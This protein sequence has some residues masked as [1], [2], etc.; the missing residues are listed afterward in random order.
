MYRDL[1]ASTLPPYRL[2]ASSHAECFA[3]TAG[4][5][6]KPGPAPLQPIEQTSETRGTG[7]HGSVP[8]VA[9]LYEP[10]N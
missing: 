3:L 7:T 5:E 1:A 6:K 8:T 4:E 10:Y 9:N 2:A